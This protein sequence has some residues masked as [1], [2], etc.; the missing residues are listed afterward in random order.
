MVFERINIFSTSNTWFCV[1]VTFELNLTF[2]FDSIFCKCR[3]Y[4]F[5]QDFVSKHIKILLVFV[6]FRNGYRRGWGTEWFIRGEWY[7]SGG[8]GV[9]S[10]TGFG[11][12][13]CMYACLHIGHLFYF[14][15]IYCKLVLIKMTLNRTIVTTWKYYDLIN[16][17]D[18]PQYTFVEV[19]CWHKHS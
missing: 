10:R 15:L 8:G 3:P 1:N 5:Q 2:D 11:R 12:F 13:R 17:L 7:R 18:A 9:W 14:L 16:E 6:V 4:L 19:H